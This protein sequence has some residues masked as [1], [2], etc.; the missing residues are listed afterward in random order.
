[1]SD[2]SAAIS[3]GVFRWLDANAKL[4][5]G[6]IREEVA[7]NMASATDTLAGATALRIGKFLDSNRAELITAIAAAVAA[8]YESR[9]NPPSAMG[10]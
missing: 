9:R 7:R 4:V 8:S 1:M 6:I 10:G 3:D 5:H 2:Y